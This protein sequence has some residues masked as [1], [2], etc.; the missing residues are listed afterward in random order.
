MKRKAVLTSLILLSVLLC[1]CGAAK[2]SQEKVDANITAGAVEQEHTAIADKLIIGTIYTGNENDDVVSAVAVKDGVI[3]YVGDE[4]GA[5]TFTDDNT[6]CLELSQGEMIIPGFVDAHTHVS[7][8]LGAMMQMAAIPE[9]ATAEDCV[10]VMRKFVEEHPNASVIK[11]KGWVN[12]VFN[13]G[14]PTADLLDAIDTDKPMVIQSSDGHSSWVNSAMMKYVNI[15]KDTPDPNGGKI[16]RYED[17]TPNGC[18]RDTAMNLISGAFP[19]ATPE[20]RIPGI[21]AAMEDYSSYGYTD[22]LEIITNEQAKPME[23]PTLDAYEILEQEGKLILN[24]QGGYVVNNEETALDV[25][26]EAIRLREQTAG[27]RFQLTDIKIFM[28]GVIEGA[29]AYLSEP[30][31]TDPKK[32][33]TSR[34]ESKEDLELLTKVIIRANEAGMPVHFHAIGDKAISDAIDCVEKAYNELGD[35]VVNCRNVITHLQIV[36]ENDFDRMAK[37]GMVAV[38][39]PWCTKYPHFYNETEVAYL[40][41]ERASNEYPVKSFKDHGVHISFGTDY[42]ASFTY[43]T[44]PCLHILVTRMTEDENP[45]SQLKASECLPVEEVLKM[46]SSGAAYQLKMEDIFGSIAEGKR[47]DLVVLSKNLLEV[48]TSEILSTDIIKTMANGVWVYEK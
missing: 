48:P 23:H 16:E 45:E 11:G 21:L 28:D 6:E 36:N 32:F 9:G 33:G 41:E 42:G 12:S 27:G 15:T 38:I 30:Y 40:G 7:N 47:A 8:Y 10:E 26:E 34:W 31:A 13:N 17:G 46:M 24:V 3:L 22:Y 25:L 44:M 14:C 19:T 4:E 39:N 29:T 2:N 5:A 18:F 37:L 20:D 43:K 35:A 1:G